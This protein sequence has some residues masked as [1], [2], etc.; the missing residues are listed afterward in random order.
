[1]EFEAPTRREY[2]EIAT[3]CAMLPLAIAFYLLSPVALILLWKTQ[4]QVLWWSILAA[5][6]LKWIFGTIVRGRYQELY[7][8]LAPD[9]PV[10]A[11]MADREVKQDRILRFCVWSH[12]ATTV[13]SVSLNA[14]GIYLGWNHVAS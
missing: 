10:S 7:E 3:G 8:A 2:A 11:Y 13:M 14:A 12:M 4:Y 6:S 1:M 5:A 9:N